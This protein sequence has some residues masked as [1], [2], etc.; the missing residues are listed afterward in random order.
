M[1]KCIVIVF[2][3]SIN[4]S[5]GSIPD[6]QRCQKTSDCAVSQSRCCTA[7]SSNGNEVRI[8]GEPDIRIVP[9]GN[10]FR[11]YRFHCPID[12]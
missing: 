8:C 2:A 9:D 3:I 5:T 1:K 6:W 10:E 11:T 12:N 7:T 4:A